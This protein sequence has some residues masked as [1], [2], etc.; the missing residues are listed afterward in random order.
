MATYDA[1]GNVIDENGSY[2]SYDSEYLDTTLYPDWYSDPNY[3]DPEYLATTAVG[4]GFDV[5]GI[6]WP[7]VVPN[8]VDKFGP[9][10]LNTVFKNGKPENGIN[11]AGLG[12]L[13]NMGGSVAEMLGFD[14]GGGTSGGY[15]KPVPKMTAVQEAVQY[16]NTNRRPGQG[17]RRYFSD[18]TY[19]PEGGDTATAR[20]AAQ[21]QA[22]GIA[23]AAPSYTPASTSASETPYVAPWERESSAMRQASAG[24]VRGDVSMEMAQIDP[25]T[26]GLALAAGGQVPKFNGQLQDKGFVVPGD[27]VRHADPMGQA[28]K[29][30]GLQALHKS[31]GVEAIRGPG[32]AMSDSIPATIDGKEPA[33]VA[34]GEA[35]V[36]PEN[37]AR[38][39]GGDVD[40]GS[41]RLYEIMD[42]LR[43]QRTG[44]S[45]QINPDNPQEL[46]AAYGGSVKRYNEAGI[47][48]ADTPT[49]A[50][51][52]SA[53]GIPLDTSVSSSLSPWVGDYVTD[54]LG[55]ADALAAKPY[56]AYTGP[57]TAGES[58]LQSQ[59]FKGMSNVANAGFTPT[60]FTTGTFDSAAA[61]QYMNPYLQASLDPQLKE[62]SR[63]AKIQSLADSSALTKAGA[64]G[65]GR[66][67]IMSSE[68]NRN[69]LDK[70][71]DMLATGYS[72]AY[73]KAMGQFNAEQGRGLEA[74]Q[75]TEASRQNSAEFGRQSLLDL[76][77]LGGTQRQIEAEGVAADKA[78]FEEERGWAYQMPQ[79]L[80][81]LLGA[82]LPVGT[83][84]TSEN[85]DWQSQVNQLLAQ[86]GIV[87]DQPGS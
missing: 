15:N 86:L 12:A 39:G 53:T 8:L 13:I 38:A 22:Q 21:T 84:T 7:N 41:S 59:A 33:R 72:N 43:Q 74:Q 71:Q 44:S 47:V 68:G 85:Q 29:E 73:D 52:P 2:N 65:G 80:K 62:L 20:T 46:R 25:A 55:E 31:F 69:L 77:N 49:A 76:A 40:Q 14:I 42:S 4:G 83:N 32:D 37:V 28:N 61:Q 18:V 5:S 9:T 51:A 63:Q 45:K 19:V 27:V 48:N 57:L 66:Q 50:A 67:A 54:F 3:Y 78:Q 11:I 34:N 64:F 82:N 81:D 23:A 56:E 6:D 36:R 58:D 26:G 60:N 16:D 30:R 24:P 75:S 10:I 70:Q 1:F 35:Y 79:Y 17:G 87:L